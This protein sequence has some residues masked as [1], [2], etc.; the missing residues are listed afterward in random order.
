MR[1]ID[2]ATGNFVERSVGRALAD[3]A[4][5]S[6]Q[7]LQ[8]FG[9]TFVPMEPTDGWKDHVLP[10]LGFHNKTTMEWEGLGADRLIDRLEQR[11]KELGG[12]SIR[13]AKVTALIMENG[14]LG[15]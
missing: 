7:W 6:I 2:E 4:A 14:A 5:R 13:G 10:P 11:T 1:V 15:A 12:D 3:N 9:T 8:S